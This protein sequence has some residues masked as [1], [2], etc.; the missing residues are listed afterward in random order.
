MVNPAYPATNVAPDVRAALRRARN[1]KKKEQTV[2][3]KTKTPAERA[4]SLKAARERHRIPERIAVEP[5]PVYG[6]DS[7]HSYFRDRATVDAADQH[8]S[9]ARFA[10]PG[11]TGSPGLFDAHAVHGGLVDARRR[12][13][14]V[15]RRDIDTGL[16]SGGFVAAGGV[17][18]FVSELF[19]TA[20][21]AGAPLAAALAG[22][23]LPRGEM[24]IRTPRVATGVSAAIQATQNTAVS[25]T[26]MVGATVSSPIG[27]IAGIQDM[28][29]QL[30]EQIPGGR[31]DE[32]V[33][34][35]LAAAV[36]A[37]LETQ[38]VQGTGS[39]GQ[40]LGLLNVSGVTS[41]TYTDASPTVAKGWSQGLQ[42]PLAAAHAAMGAPADL[43]ILHPRRAR[44]LSAG[45]RTAP[46]W[47]AE[48]VETLGVPTNLGGG[49]NED[50]IILTRRE[51]TPLL[52]RPIRIRT[53][54]DTLAGNLTVRFSAYLMAAL[55]VRQ[56]AAVTVVSG[57]GLVTPTFP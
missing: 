45:D 52:S 49:T 26:D 36:A 53:H 47:P 42:S 57:T 14:S 13:A 17:P 51:F 11:P 7:T 12:L 55:V 56:P 15:E 16:G 29:V 30:L 3:P 18:G 54:P 20:L 41:A 8:D 24:T 46:A 19:A 25:E 27:T 33:T 6:P 10:G 4:E 1:P 31:G 23:E 32:A 28:A 21:R 38:C 5:R 50:R 43:I 9:E 37:Q 44:Y 35:E 39:S 22:G 34:R 2:A 40:L 48:H